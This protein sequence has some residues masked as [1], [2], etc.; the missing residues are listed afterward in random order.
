MSEVTAEMRDR[1][2]DA[3]GAWGESL[4][5]KVKEALAA[6]GCAK[7]PPSVDTDTVVRQ[8]MVEFAVFV[9]A[10]VI[11]AVERAPAGDAGE[12]RL[13]ALA[14]S[15]IPA[16][17]DLE[18]TFEAGAVKSIADTERYVRVLAADPVI[19]E[20]A[21]KFGLTPRDLARSMAE[22]VVE[23]TTQV[24]RSVVPV[25]FK[26]A[27]EDWSM[28]EFDERLTKALQGAGPGAPKADWYGDPAGRHQ[29]RYWDGASWTDHVA[30]DGASSLDPM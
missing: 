8:V 3:I 6:T 11:D 12:A 17:G 25:V 13:A 21:K 7:S 5:V 16:L 14:S 10:L 2:I 15:S 26:V 20:K 22:N 29:F 9:G 30:D 24:V 23:A 28:V 27:Q 1:I 18:D 19:A 4:E